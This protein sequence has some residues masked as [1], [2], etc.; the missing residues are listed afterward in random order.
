MYMNIHNINQNWYVQG[1][2]V[3]SCEGYVVNLEFEIFEVIILCRLWFVKYCVKINF[4]Y[5][6][7]MRIEFYKIYH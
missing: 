5:F 1:Y 4:I 2:V 3:S 6:E 7:W